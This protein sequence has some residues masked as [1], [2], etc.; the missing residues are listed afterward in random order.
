MMKRLGSRSCEIIM[1]IGKAMGGS[2]EF[3]AFE[4]ERE[5]L[6]GKWTTYTVSARSSPGSGGIMAYQYILYYVLIVE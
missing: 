5:N 4:R 3:I 2:D 6:R 1:D